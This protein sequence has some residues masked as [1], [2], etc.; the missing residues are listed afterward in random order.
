MDVNW[1][2]L[3][4]TGSTFFFRSAQARR[5]RAWVRQL[6]I[7]DQSSPGK[8]KTIFKSSDIEDFFYTYYKDL[9]TRP[10]PFSTY[11][12]NNFF[13]S[14][15]LS[16]IPKFDSKYND[17]LN[18]PIG[19]EELLNATSRLNK[20]SCGGPD[21]ISAKLLAWFIERCP[22]LILKALNDQMCLGDTNDK[23]INDRNIIQ[24]N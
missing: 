22:N 17:D 11:N 18:S 6:Q 15:F 8:S 12:F 7:P 23:P 10:D 19:F 14:D 2:M 3:G 1:A 9:N 24:T 5:H 13:P 16:T 20:S 4:E 21:G